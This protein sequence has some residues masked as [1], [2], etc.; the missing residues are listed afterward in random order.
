MSACFPTGRIIDVPK[1]HP[2][3]SAVYKI[4]GPSRWPASDRSCRPYMG[5][6]RFVPHL[7]TILDDRG[8]P[9]MFINW[10]TDMGDAGNGPTS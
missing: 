4:D 8:R 6:G 7:R 3:F 5:E 2:V 9:M 1:D 10:N